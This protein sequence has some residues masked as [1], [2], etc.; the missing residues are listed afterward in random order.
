MTFPVNQNMQ[1]PK[2]L[3]CDGSNKRLSNPA[4]RTL[5]L[6]IIVKIYTVQTDIIRIIVDE[7]LYN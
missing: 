3:Y 4:I 2:S 7:I 5:P 1:S 6:R